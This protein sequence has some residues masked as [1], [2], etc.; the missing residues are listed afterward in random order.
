MV[1]LSDLGTATYHWLGGE[2][3]ERE[4]A[5]VST[6]RLA[7]V[8]G[9]LTIAQIVPTEDTLVRPG[10][11]SNGPGVQPEFVRNVR[12]TAR[13]GPSANRDNARSP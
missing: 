6:D 12:F 5:D 10:R 13:S 11:S 7:I 2:L 9:L 4:G 8:V 3:H 1:Q